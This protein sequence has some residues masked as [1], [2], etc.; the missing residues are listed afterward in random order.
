M[1]DPAT[2]TPDQ[3]AGT[4]C[5]VDG[6]PVYPGAVPVGLLGDVED[7]HFVYAC[8]GP[9]ARQVDAL[10]ME[11]TP[12]PADRSETPRPDRS[13]VSLGSLS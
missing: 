2:L 10:V 5:V 4:A 3:Y 11:R 12:K 6:Y 9:C 1:I 8:P 7:L 13:A